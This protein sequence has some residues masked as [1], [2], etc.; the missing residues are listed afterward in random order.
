M[1]KNF[2]CLV[3][4]LLFFVGGVFA[5]RNP[6]KSLLERVRERNQ[7]RVEEFQR[8]KDEFQQERIQNRI[9]L[10][11]QLRKS[12]EEAQSQLER[13][14]ERLRQRLNKITDE[15]KR[16]ITEKVVERINELNKN[17]TN[18][19]FAILVHLETILERI[20]SRATKV[21]L[22]G[23][24][25]S[26]VEEAIKKAQEKIE[27]AREAVKEQAGKVYSL[28]QID[29]EAALRIKVGELR[30]NFHQDVTKVKK[31]VFEAREAVR[32]AAVTLAQIPR[33]DEIELPTSTPA[34]SQ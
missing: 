21:A 18:H 5:Q 29:N 19:Y 33:V 17:I 31:L 15:R 6:D 22:R 11:D 7:V 26:E 24:N 3:C 27:I 10:R 4:V 16:H 28:P 1:R 12:Q 2:F 30:Q 8:I 9:E 14:R 25:V 23:I 13:E 34:T 20:E 32:N